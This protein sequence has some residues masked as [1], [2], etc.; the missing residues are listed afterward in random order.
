MNLN[1]KLLIRINAILFTIALLGESFLILGLTRG[2]WIN[3]DLYRRI[4]ADLELN[5]EVSPPP[6]FLV[7][8]SRLVARAMVDVASAKDGANLGNSRKVQEFQQ[9]FPQLIKRYNERRQYFLANPLI[10]SEAKRLLE[11]SVSQSA[12]QWADLVEN[13]VAPAISANNRSLALKEYQ[14]IGAFFDIHQREND[15]FVEQSNRHILAQEKEAANTITQSIV[16]ATILTLLLLLL[17]YVLLYLMQRYS[18]R[19]LGIIANDLGASA[20]QFVGA[21]DQVASSSKKLALASDQV[22]SSSQQLAEGA[23]EQAAAIE[24]T[25]ASLEEISSMIHSTASNAD[26]AKSLAS[27][28]QASA[29]MGLSSMG[30]MTNAMAAIED[31]SNQVVKIVKSIDEIAFQTNILALNA[32]VEAARAGEAGA[33][34]AVV[35]EEVRSLAQ[36]SAAAANESA[37]KIEAAI[38]NS[39]QGSECLKSVSESFNLIEAKIKQTDNLVAEIALAAKEQAQGIEQITLA[40]QEMSKVAQGSAI[41]I[42]QMSKVAQTSAAD[43]ERIAIASEKMRAQAGHQHQIMVGL[44]NVVDGSSGLES[45][46][47]Q[48]NPYLLSESHEDEVSIA[49]SSKRQ[50]QPE[51]I[52]DHFRD[53]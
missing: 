21:S 46:V 7:E 8:A 43:T 3:G 22:A 25:S 34:F 40:I 2:V 38:L 45:V 28:A 4:N 48:S 20:E 14:Q 19:P 15:K 35:A 26:L 52:D 24:Q 1:I 29:Q 50:V 18:I 47:G 11:G 36:R 12:T 32:A 13:K 5:S 51:R 31:S 49:K 30:Q 42:D 33:G 6:L 39:K 16:A 41:S 10:D 9:Q 27:E 17:S 23:S 37:T 44:R 53:F